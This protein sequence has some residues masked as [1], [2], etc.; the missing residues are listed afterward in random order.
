[1]KDI[2]VI[3]VQ[4]N[5]KYLSIVRGVTAKMGEIYGLSDSATEDVRLAVDEACSNVI[6]HAYEGDITQNII[7][8]FRMSRKG[9]EVL[10]EDRGLKAHPESMEG[11][12]LNDI[13]PGGLGLHLIKRAFDIF[14]F[15]DRKKKGNRLRLVRFRR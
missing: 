8:K 14:T 1:M 15:D 2:V 9:F 5:P 11:R 7:V 12:D 13:R 10:I 4:S 3:K 6:K